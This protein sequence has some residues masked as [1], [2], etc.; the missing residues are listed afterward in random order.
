MKKLNFGAGGN[1]IDGFENYDRDVDI[2]KPLAWPDDSVDMILAEHLIEHVPTPDFFR[3]VLECK[4]ILVCGGTLRLCVPVLN[5]VPADH[6]RDLILG[7]GHVAAY[8]QDS[9]RQILLLADLHTY[10][11]NSPRDPVDGHWNVIG[12]EK[13]DLETFRVECVK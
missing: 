1:I 10:E 3:F 2:T 9:L 4:R 8:T 11:W 7:H 12:I 13:D 5:S 6:A